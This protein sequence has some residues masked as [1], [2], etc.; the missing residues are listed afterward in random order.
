MSPRDD[1]ERLNRAINQFESARESFPDEEITS[2]IALNSKLPSPVR[3]VAAILQMLPPGSR[4]FGL[5]FMLA[6]IAFAIWRG[7]VTWG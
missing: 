7:V 6:L 1:I 2:V 5:A 4:I 3:G